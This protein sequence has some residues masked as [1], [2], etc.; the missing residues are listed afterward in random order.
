MKREILKIKSKQK[1]P[2]TSEPNPMEINAGKH[3]K[4]L[5]ASTPR[6]VLEQ[7]QSAINAS[8]PIFI[9]MKHGTGYQGLP[10]KLED[11]WLYMVDSIIYG[12]KQNALSTNLVI[13]LKDCSQIAHVNDANCVLSFLSSDVSG[14]PK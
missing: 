9:Q 8:N 11:G 4:Q 10:L 5:T 14:D 2:S 7:I 3:S 1:A 13:Q 6:I 12:T